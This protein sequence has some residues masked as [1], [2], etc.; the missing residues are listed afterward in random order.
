MCSYSSIST[1][2]C[3]RLIGKHFISSTSLRLL[4]RWVPSSNA[5]V[6]YSTNTIELLWYN[7]SRKFFPHWSRND[8]INMKVIE[9]FVID[10]LAWEKIIKWKLIDQIRDTFILRFNRYNT[11]YASWKVISSIIWVPCNVQLIC[12][13]HLTFII[14]YTFN[15][16]CPTSDCMLLETLVSNESRMQ[17]CALSIDR[18][19]TFCRRIYLYSFTSACLVKIDTVYFCIF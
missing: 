4:A 7:G 17:H 5:F 8:T 11:E 9:Q 14:Q 3:T 12:R 10:K 19:H 13:Y 2:S 1:S 15:E 6:T 16:V 18:S